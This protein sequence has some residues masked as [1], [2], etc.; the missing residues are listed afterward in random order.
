M[1]NLLSGAELAAFPA[2]ANVLDRP[3][4]ELTIAEARMALEE[5]I[6]GGMQCNASLL[7]R[8]LLAV[9]SKLEQGQ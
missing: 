2:V 5:T 7:T 9:V 3:P 8:L 1:A 4:Q 6:A